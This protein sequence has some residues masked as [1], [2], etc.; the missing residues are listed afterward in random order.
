MRRPTFDY[1]DDLRAGWHPTL[2]E[3]P[4]VANSVSLL[5]PY[6]EPYVVRA[7][8]DALPQLEATGAT[9]ATC[10]DR[11][12][13]T[14]ARAYAAQESAHH[15][16]H[17]RF[18][19]LVAGQVRGV[20]ALERVMARVYG[21]LWDRRSDRFHLA[22][23]A[24]SEAVAYGIARWV[25]RHHHE[26]FRGADPTVAALYLWH[27]AEE[28]EH[29][30][31]AVAVYDRCYGTRR[32][33]VGALAVSILVLAAFVIAGTVVGLWHERRLFHPVAIARLTR[34]TLQFVFSELPNMVVATLPGHRP[35]DFTDP[36]W[37]AIYLAT[38]F[39]AELPT[40]TPTESP[41]RNPRAA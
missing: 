19:D 29:K 2:P 24:A 31:V 41:R 26:L 27:L 1:P 3:L 15:A 5:M 38:E 30:D 17:R 33:L 22:F 7:V 39:P 9:G 35:S 8:R 25:E 11:Q 16:Q 34:W 21:R 36:A 23:A 6:V 12:L 37:F 13:A 18:N 28:V 10:T 32:H 40:T 20:A 4:C 14:D